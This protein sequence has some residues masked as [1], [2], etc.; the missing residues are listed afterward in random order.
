VNETAVNETAIT[1]EQDRDDAVVKIRMPRSSWMWLFVL[2]GSQFVFAAGWLAL[3]SSW[4]AAGGLATGGLGVGT[5]WWIRTRGV[6][7]T[8]E[9]AIVRSVRRRNIPWQDVQAVLQYQRHSDWGVRLILESAEP[10]TLRAPTTWSG[11]GGAQF[12]RDFHRI[13][14]WWLAHRGEAWRPVRAEAPQPPAQ[15]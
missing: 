8:P 12:E 15:R 1:G 14:Q 2:A 7:L 10:V 5:G 3:G 13:G 4:L 6:D 9:S 11:F